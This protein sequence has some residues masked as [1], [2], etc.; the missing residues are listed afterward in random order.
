M[1]KPNFTHSSMMSDG[2]TLCYLNTSIRLF[3]KYGYLG[4]KYLSKLFNSMNYNY[5]SVFI[6]NNSL[7]LHFYQHCLYFNIFYL[8]ACLNIY[9]GQD[10]QDG[11]D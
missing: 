1:S 3:I 2:S 9:S 11:Q 8:R 5:I 10:L 7:F 4:N 6:S